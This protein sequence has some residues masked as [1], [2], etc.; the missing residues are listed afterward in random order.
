[1]KFFDVLQHTSTFVLALIGF[2][3]HSSLIEIKNIRRNVENIQIFACLFGIFKM[4]TAEQKHRCN[5]RLNGA[6]F[7]LVPCSQTDSLSHTHI[8][9][10]NETLF[11]T[12]TENFELYLCVVTGWFVE[13]KYPACFHAEPVISI[14]IHIK[15]AVN[16]IIS[17]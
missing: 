14:S 16:I 2:T 9:T 8:N 13:L 4:A 3:P 1:M 6:L 11:K 7:C 5:Y 17:E 12:N 15:T 10:L